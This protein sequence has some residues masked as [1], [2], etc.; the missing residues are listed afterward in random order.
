MY[1]LGKKQYLSFMYTM[2]ANA[3]AYTP[4]YAQS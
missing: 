3:S 4:F 2:Y 1:T